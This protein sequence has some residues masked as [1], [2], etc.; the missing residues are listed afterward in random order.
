MSRVE[1][2]DVHEH[3]TVAVDLDRQSGRLE[4]ERGQQFDRPVEQ[5]PRRDRLLHA[6]EYDLPVGALELDRDPSRPRLEHHGLGSQG[7]AYRERGAEHGMAGE[8]KLLG[9]SEDAYPG[10]AVT[11]GRQHKNGLGEVH[12]PGEAL[13]VLSAEGPAVEEHAELVALEGASSEDVH[14][15]VG[16]ERRAAKPVDP[17]CVGKRSHDG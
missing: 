3:R 11:F 14:H 2:L 5:L 10:V 16:M 6:A 17:A 12:L 4:A 9:R 1:E 8:G 13:H 15:Q 7:G